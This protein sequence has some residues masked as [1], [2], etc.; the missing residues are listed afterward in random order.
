METRSKRTL[1]EESREGSRDNRQTPLLPV[2][3]IYSRGGQL[4]GG[5][6]LPGVRFYFHKRIDQGLPVVLTYHPLYNRSAN[7]ASEGAKRSIKREKVESS[8]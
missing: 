7:S 1:A 4:K 3:I 5:R 6:P 8:K 2:S